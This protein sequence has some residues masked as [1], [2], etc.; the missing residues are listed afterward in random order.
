MVVGQ[1]TP[2]YTPVVAGA[3]GAIDQTDPF[4]RSISVWLPPP[5]PV[6]K[7]SVVDGHDTPNSWVFSTPASF[8]LAT[9]DHD[10]P[11]QRSVSVR[12]VGDD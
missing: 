4:H 11:F 6:A 7:H 8:G 1:L 12:A 9:T 3:F 10:V 5:A 2:K